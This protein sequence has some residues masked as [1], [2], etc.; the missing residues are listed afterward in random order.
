MASD[1]VYDPLAIEGLLS[2][3]GPPMYPITRLFALAASSLPARQVRQTLA[4]IG[5]AVWAGAPITAPQRTGGQF[6]GCMAFGEPL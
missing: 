1:M 3:N 5:V 6:S 2:L 4:A